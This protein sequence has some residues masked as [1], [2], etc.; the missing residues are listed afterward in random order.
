VERVAHVF[1]ICEGA[2]RADLA[3]SRWPTGEQR[4]ESFLEVTAMS[5]GPPRPLKRV[6][7]VEAL[8]SK[9]GDL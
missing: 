9:I 2:D 8:P 1:T 3:S 4:I 5:Y 7:E 6:I